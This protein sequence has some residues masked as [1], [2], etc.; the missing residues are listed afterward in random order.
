MS[1][2][3]ILNIIIRLIYNFSLYFQHDPSRLCTM[4]LAMHEMD[5]LPDDILDC[6]PPP[7]LWEFVTERS[8]GEVARSVTSRQYPFAQLAKTL[9]QREQLKILRMR[10]PDMSD[11]LDFS[12]PVRDWNSTTHAEKF[13]PDVGQSFISSSFSPFNTDYY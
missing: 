3:N 2:N 11:G 1:N 7:A 6:G 4:T 13:F 10:Y 12:E 9:I 8:M 5:H